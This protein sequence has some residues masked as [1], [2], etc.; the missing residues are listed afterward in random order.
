LSTGGI[1]ARAARS[2]ARRS[3]RRVVG[4]VVAIAAVGQFAWAGVSLPDALRNAV[5]GGAIVAFAGLAGGSVVRWLAIPRLRPLDRVLFAVAMG[6]GVLGIL[7]LGIAAAG[8]LHPAVV[9]A[10]CAATAAAGAAYARPRRVIAPALRESARMFDGPD[11]LALLAAAVLVLGAICGASAIPV[12]DWDSLMYHLRV[13]EL[14]LERGRIFLP[15]DSEHVAQVGAVHMLYV[16]AAALG[17]PQAALVVSGLLAL[18]L[19]LATFRAAARLAGPAAGR[20]AAAGLAGCTV[21]AFVAFTARTDATLALLVFLAHAAFVRAARG[22]HP[23]LL[24]AA[25]IL[26]GI[27]LG[28]KVH[29]AVYAAPLVLWATVLV[30]ARRLPARHVALG[31]ALAVGL[32]APWLLKNALLLGDPFFPLLAG[33]QIPPWLAADE[34]VRMVAG[35]VDP[36][37][38]GRAR[39][40]FSLSALV[41]RPAALSPESNARFYLWSPLLFGG[42]VAALVHRRSWAWVL[43][44][45]GY[46]GLL[47]GYS[48]QTNLRYLIAALPA[49]A[50]ASA[51]AVTALFARFGA[52][53]AWAVA[54]TILALV[55]LARP[56]DVL[57]VRLQGGGYDDVHRIAS[58]ASRTVAPGGRI[59]M[60]YDARGWAFDRPVIQDDLAVTWQLLERSGHAEECLAGLGFTHV[61]VNFGAAAFYRTRAGQS[62]AARDPSLPRFVDRCLE[63]EA[64]EGGL[65]LFRLRAP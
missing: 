41:L 1:A 64:R 37:L 30:A 40:P 54:L 49:L 15:P 58:A 34:R 12:A 42:V 65:S 35:S 36:G 13:P 48:P 53:R 6:I 38:I 22:G 33:H 45:L 32:A 3:S 55:P 10:A 19:G 7:V 24:V 39:E 21:V 25:G 8:L 27:A 60:L 47:I 62:R 11:G 46:L 16:L 26:A 5:T 44:A 4:A 14:F 31:A 9:V 63:L 57:R 43:P 20:L 52:R 61:L 51:T 23:R 17:A 59:L 56:L 28:V 2:P 18:L 29:A 50:V